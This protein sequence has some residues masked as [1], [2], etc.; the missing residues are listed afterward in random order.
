M[1]LALTLSAPDFLNLRG[2]SACVSNGRFGHPEQHRA[3]S[4]REA[5]CLQTFPTTYQFYGSLESRA[6]QIGNAVPPKFAEAIG[7]AIKE[8]AQIA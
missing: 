1:T 5:A 6:T 3:I 4:A 7:S 8:H 2:Q